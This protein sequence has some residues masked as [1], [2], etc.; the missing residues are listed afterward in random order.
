MGKMKVGIIGC[1][2]IAGIYVHNL[3]N[4]FDKVEVYSCSDLVP[5]RAEEL[6]A[7]FDLNKAYSNEEMLADPEVDIIM[8]LAVPKVHFQLNKAILESG[9]HL[10]CEK[11]LCV[12]LEEANE[13]IELGHKLGLRV[14]CAPDTFLGPGIQ[15]VRKVLDEGMIGEIVGFNINMM[16]A[17]SEIWHPSPAFLY[18]RGGG[19]M[20]DVGPYYLT[21]LCSLLG[22]VEEVCCYA[23]TSFRPRDIRTKVLETTDVN[24]HYSGIIKMCSGVYGNIFN[25]WEVWHSSFHGMEIY[26]TEGMVSVPNPNAT[27]GPVYLYLAKDYMQEMDKIPRDQFFERLMFMHHHEQDYY[28]EIPLAYRGGKNMRG[29]VT[30]DMAMSIEAGC[31]HRTPGEMGS[32]IVDILDCFDLSAA[33]HR[34]VKLNTT[35]EKPEAFYPVAEGLWLGDLGTPSNFV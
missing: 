35:F 6:R 24:T 10:Y 14:S 5:E 30:V 19:P 20:H 18:E 21:A 4:H 32:H 28:K 16:G 7:R 3:K 12:T 33:E 9:K 31:P 17:G 27:E 13:I 1:G 11:P 26:G 22:P 34:I 15:T 2:A 29:V 23:S 8:N 25:S